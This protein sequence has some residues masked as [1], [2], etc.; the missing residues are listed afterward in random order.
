MWPP[1]KLY[2]VLNNDRSDRRSETSF[3]WRA[4]GIAASYGKEKD[5]RPSGVPEMSKMSLP[6]REFVS[7]RPN[8]VAAVSDST[9]WC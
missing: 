4:D 6:R 5:S 8:S 1:S 7:T 3:P 9:L 2:H